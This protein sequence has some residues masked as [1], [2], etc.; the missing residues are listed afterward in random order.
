MLVT[1]LVA[2]SALATAEAA[3]TPGLTLVKRSPLVVR[4]TGFRPSERVVVTA[5][6]LSGP[7]RVVVRATVLGRFTATIRTA[8]QP[9]GKPF[10]VRAVGGRGSVALLRLPS[11]ACV[12]PPID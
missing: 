3:A 9:C 6:T 11:T 8:N 2:S 1:V 4:G 5:L 7:R 10:A 12:P